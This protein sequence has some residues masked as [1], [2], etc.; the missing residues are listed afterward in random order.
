[1][2]VSRILS[3]A[4]E[5]RLLRRHTTGDFGGG[6]WSTIQSLVD[7]GMI[8]LHPRGFV[9]VTRRGEAYCNAYHASMP[10]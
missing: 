10:L 7:R 8:V 6:A 9:Y 5:R 1:M 3:P 2:T 4:Q